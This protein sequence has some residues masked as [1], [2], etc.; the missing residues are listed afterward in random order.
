MGVERLQLRNAAETAKV[1]LTNGVL[2][3]YLIARHTYK[4][5]NEVNK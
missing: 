2:K 4:P 5:N 1:N 3:T